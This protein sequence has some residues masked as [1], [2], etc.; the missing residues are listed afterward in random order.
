[1]SYAITCETFLADV[2]DHQITVLRDDGLYRHVRFSRPGT[3]CMSFNL[4]T[5]PGALCYTGDMGTYVFSRLA[6]MFEFFR[7]DRERAKPGELRINTGYWSE[8]LIAVDG[9]RRAGGA[10]EFSPD[11]FSKAIKETLVDWMRGSDHLDRAGRHELRE[12]VEDEILSNID[13]SDGHEAYRAANEFCAEIGGVKF[14]FHDLWD[15]DFTEYTHSFLWCCYALSWGIQRY[16]ELTA[17]KDSGD[18]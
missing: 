17:K 12:A 10:E 5:W 16:D 4:I 3:I 8:K 6:D 15:R 2:K 14:Q 9:N 1:M 18:E 13:C 7:T 11:K